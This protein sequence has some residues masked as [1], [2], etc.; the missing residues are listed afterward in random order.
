MTQDTGHVL[1]IYHHWS[2]ETTLC[3][4]IISLIVLFLLLYLI[5]RLLIYAA[6]LLKN[7]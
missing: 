2:I 1:I 5:L 7:M 3:V 6:H 4:A